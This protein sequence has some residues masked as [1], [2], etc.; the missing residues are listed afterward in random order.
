MMLGLACSAQATRYSSSPPFLPRYP[1]NL[2][3]YS[4]V[5]TVHAQEEAGPSA[6]SPP[7]TDGGGDD[8][9]ADP[10]LE[11]VGEAPELE[12]INVFRLLVQGGYFM[13]PIV[14]MSLV[15]VTFSIERFFGLRKSRVLPDDM[16]AALGQLGGPQGGF[17]PR[18]AYRICQQFPSAASSV[19]RAVTTS[20]SR[21]A[22]NAAWSSS[23]WSLVSSSG[24][25]AR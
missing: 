6:A 3:R 24:T 9:T 12:G 1:M 22:S 10:D 14:L 7:D 8:P 16:V 13:L 23:S 19:V 20:S 4:L 2:G 17:D 15:V 18:Q 11:T 21:R 25:S 5:A